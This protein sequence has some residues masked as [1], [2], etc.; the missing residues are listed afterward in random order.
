MIDKVMHSKFNVDQSVNYY[1]NQL[2]YTDMNVEGPL[3]N[4][5]LLS[6]TKKN[7]VRIGHDAGYDIFASSLMNGNLTLVNVVEIFDHCKIDRPGDVFYTIT[8]MERLDE[9]DSNDIKELEE[10]RSKV[11]NCLGQPTFLDDPYFLLKDFFTL[12]SFINGYNDEKLA[13][14]YLQ[15]KNIMKRDGQFIIIDPF[16]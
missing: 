9:L 5:I 8:E 3:G 12:F 16:A 1:I 13:H 7:V 2:H 14:D 10:W 6:S 4:K 15:S 11:E